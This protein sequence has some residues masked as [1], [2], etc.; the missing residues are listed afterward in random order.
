MGVWNSS[1]QT[2][3]D[4]IPMFHV[5]S[6]EKSSWVHDAFFSI[7]KEFWVVYILTSQVP[8][9]VDNNGHLHTNN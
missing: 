4:I 2:L 6:I 8:L 5:R 3:H 1:K 7:F 9:A